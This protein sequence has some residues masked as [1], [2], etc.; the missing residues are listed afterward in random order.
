MNLPPTQPPRRG[1]SPE[2]TEHY[3]IACRSSALVLNR[4]GCPQEARELWDLADQAKRDLTPNPDRDLAP[5]VLGRAGHGIPALLKAELARTLDNRA[6][7]V[8]T[9]PAR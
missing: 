4:Q 3:I 1:Q 6:Q 9:W 5:D 2:A 8:P 7:E